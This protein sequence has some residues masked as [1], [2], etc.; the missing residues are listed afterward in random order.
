MKKR[1]QD[2]KGSVKFSGKA[3]QSKK[4]K[5]DQRKRGQKYEPFAYVPLDP[6]QLS[7]KGNKRSVGRFSAVVNANKEAS[8]PS[9]K[10]QRK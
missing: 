8:K 7:A 9:K 6:K 4:G 5:G 1:Q 3:Y 10:R 2:E